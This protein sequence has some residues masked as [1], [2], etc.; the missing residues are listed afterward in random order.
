MDSR[1]PL[2]YN[3]SAGAGKTDTLAML[4]IAHILQ[5]GCG[6]PQWRGYRYRSTLCV[7]F[8]RKATAEMKERI[9]NTLFTLSKGAA[10]EYIVEGVAAHSGL[11]PEEIRHRAGVVLHSI[12]HDYSQLSVST[13]D[14]FIQRMA[15]SLLWELG[16]GGDMRISLSTGAM[17]TRA[18][19]ELFSRPLAGDSDLLAWLGG[20]LDDR[21]DG[22]GD[23]QL[24]RMIA[25]YGYTLF[26]DSFAGKPDGE[27]QRLFSMAREQMAR[28]AL[29]RIGDAARRRVGDARAALLGG[30]ARVG[31]GEGDFKGKGRS[32][33]VSVLRNT[34]PT[35]KTAWQ[36]LS[37]TALAACGKEELWFAKEELEARGAVVTLLMPL[38]SELV[39]VYNAARRAML[40]YNVCYPLLGKISALSLL[41]GELSRE[42]RRRGV[43][44]LDDLSTLLL[45]LGGE[46]EA[47]FIYERMGS[48]YD[49]F[50][51]DE[52][53]DTSRRHWKLFEGLVKNGLAEG[54]FS[55]LVGDVKQAIYRFRGGDWKLLAK[56]IPEEFGVSPTRLEY[57]YRSRHS[58]VTFNNLFFKSLMTE[59]LVAYCE[60]RRDEC[61]TEGLSAGER[62]RFDAKVREYLGGEGEAGGV[63]Q[64][65]YAGVEQRVP[66]RAKEGEGYVEFRWCRQGATGEEREEYTPERYVVEQ[67]ERV[68]DGQGVA[69]RDVAVLV[70]SNR[71]A[72]RVLA[73]V[74]DNN[75]LREG[76][77][78]IRVV[79]SD[80]LSLDASR[81]VQVVLSV[82]RMA[83]RRADEE[84]NSVDWVL[85][86]QYMMPSAAEDS[87]WTFGF[88]GAAAAQARAWI[89][90]LS[91]LPL[92]DAFDAIASRCGLLLSDPYVSDLYN[93]MYAYQRDESVDIKGFLDWYDELE[94]SQRTIEL[95]ESLD[96][97]KLLTLHK[98]KG[99]EFRVVIMPMCGWPL[100]VGTPQ[101]WGEVARA[102]W[103]DLILP[104][105]GS[106]D[107]KSSYFFIDTLEEYWLEAVDSV[108]LLYV[109]FTRAK[110]Q[111]YVYAP[112]RQNDSLWKELIRP[113]IEGHPE[114]WNGGEAR[115]E[116]AVMVGCYGVCP[117]GNTGRLPADAGGGEAMAG[118]ASRRALPRMKQTAMG[119]RAFEAEVGRQRR[120]SLGEALHSLFETRPSREEFFSVVEPFIAVGV[121]TAERA[122]T[123]WVE[124]EE[125]M[126]CSPMRDCFGGGGEVFEERDILAGGRVYRPDRVVVFGH[127][128]V[129]VDFKFAGR[130]SRHGQYV[131]QVVGYTSA[132]R[133]MGYEEVEGYLW[134]LDPRRRAVGEDGARV[135]RCV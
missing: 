42:E 49:S 30:M 80:A 38:Y 97:V 134:Y 18:T 11:T 47:P 71:D 55:L 50:L 116:G 53:Q 128:A 14:S 44:L 43:L 1:K 66:A 58:I 28:E 92:L 69:Q 125:D 19:E 24:V 106:K 33:M 8:T 73:A 120:R 94:D 91:Q 119:G 6:G 7:T 98:S 103:P 45:D 5:G 17:V 67:L 40:S 60:R 54:G 111:L 20:R 27:R 84:S 63:I 39:R 25:E 75:R 90:R 99:L 52:F 135:V 3:A 59:A 68:L 123:L 29:T 114:L 65:A 79:T 102:G 26:S 9:L 101:L 70:R 122:G 121:L 32:F 83:V 107:S 23:Y 61:L 129:V 10:A 113:V 35:S 36:E 89:A 74:L 72:A 22:G 78:A 117:A 133:A 110:E 57:N 48:R 62:A 21:L 34:D 124:I 37:P 100:R 81:D 118:A 115:G 15:S 4:Y 64:N 95:P 76:R 127:R 126:H 85:L 51:I 108:N 12:V 13:I 130:D 86:S 131:D 87:A 105:L 77:E 2:I 56:E 16:V 96:A 82:L 132:L 109:A 46:Q 104:F 93:R 88:L 112:G 41:R 31:V